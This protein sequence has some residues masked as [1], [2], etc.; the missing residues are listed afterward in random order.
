MLLLLGE[1]GRYSAGNKGFSKR[2]RILRILANKAE[3]SRCNRQILYQQQSTMLSMM[4]RPAA[5]GEKKSGLV[6][7][8]FANEHF[9]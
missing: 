2:G 5:R 8:L 7:I 6:A 9:R 4:H 3:L 1:Q